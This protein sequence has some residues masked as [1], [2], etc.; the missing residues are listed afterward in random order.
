MKKYQ[1]CNYCGKEIGE[2][3]YLLKYKVENDYNSFCSE[4]CA[5]LIIEVSIA[6]ECRSNILSEG[7][8]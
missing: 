6:I 4:E 8:V 1:Y 3:Y 5:R 7:D 2:N